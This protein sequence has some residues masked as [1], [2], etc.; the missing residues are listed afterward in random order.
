METMLANRQYVSESRLSAAIPTPSVLPPRLSDR[1]NSLEAAVIRDG[2]VVPS[3]LTRIDG[4][5]D[6]KVGDSVVFG[7]HVFKSIASVDAWLATLLQPK[8]HQLLADFTVQLYDI[9]GTV[10]ST[11][12][13]VA[14]QAASKKAEFDSAEAAT[15][16]STFAIEF[17]PFVIKA[18]GKPA[19]A[20]Q[21]GRV[22]TA[23]FNSYSVYD[24]TV[25]ASTFQMIKTKIHTNRDNRQR[26]IDMHLPPGEASTAPYHAVFSE[27]LRLGS[28]QVLA[29]ADSLKTMYTTLLKAGFSDKNAWDRVLTYVKSV[30]E[31]VHKVRTLVKSHTPG[32]MLMGMFKATLLLEEYRKLEF[33]RHPY[34][35]SA[36]VIASM[37]RE[38][39]QLGEALKQLEG[40]FKTITNNSAALSR[41]EAIIQKLQ[42]KNPDL[43]R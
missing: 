39:K 5:E 42:T 33:V 17:P 36:L 9:E 20:A 31:N 43:F 8:V 6:R 21:Q 26:D 2:G 7:N 38:G 30:F 24:G 32:S 40:Y 34:V 23:P 28:A 18:S 16:M 10:E 4:L 12:E 22:F 1:L 11:K 15:T 29:F 41:L 35:S 37:Q 27:V 3:L 14:L 25:D 13:F 19:D